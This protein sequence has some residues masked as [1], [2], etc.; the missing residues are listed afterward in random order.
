MA[1]RAAQVIDA[2]A[3]LLAANTSLQAQVFKNR[4]LVLSEDEGELPAV[5]VNFGADEPDSVEELNRIGSA[6][7]VVLTAACVGDSEAEVLAAL[8]E[9]RRQSHI[10]LMADTSLGLSFVWH[11]VYGGASIPQLQQGE[12]MCGALTTRW[13]VRYAMNITDPQ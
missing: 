3:A 10:A 9:L 7:E 1:H 13:T 2:I 12:R 8:L 4:T 5:T 6:L 11:T